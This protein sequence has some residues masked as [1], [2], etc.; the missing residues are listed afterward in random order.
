ME[1]AVKECVVINI[2]DE[3][4][5]LKGRHEACKDAFLQVIQKLSETYLP[6]NG[7]N[8]VQD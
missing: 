8:T 1:A 5:M 6:D 2:L 3:D 4:E 7:R